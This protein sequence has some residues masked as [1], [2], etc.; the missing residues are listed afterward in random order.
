MRKPSTPTILLASLVLLSVGCL[1]RSQPARYYVLAA[2]AESGAAAVQE[3]VVVVGPIETPAYLDRPQM[4]TR[5]DT[6]ELSMDASHRWA[7]PLS[8]AMHQVLADN[9]SSLTGSQRVVPALTVRVDRG[10]RVRGVVSRFEADESGEVVL[11]VTWAVQPVRE[12]RGGDRAGEVRRS[13]YK[14]MSPPETPTARV[15][16]MNRLLLRWSEDIAAALPSGAR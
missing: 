9:I 5:L 2:R 12:R 15:E 6:G 13:V 3:P 4:V 8:T 7:Q 11:E 1:G 14:E 16:A 10:Y